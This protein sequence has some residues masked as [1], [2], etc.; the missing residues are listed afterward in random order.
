MAKAGR[1]LEELV[2]TLESLLAG[3]GV[4]LRSPEIIR[5]KVSKTP[6]EIDVTMRSRIG[7]TPVLVMME[8]R[9][10][11]RIQDVQWI[12]EIAGKKED[13]GA[14]KAVAVSRKGFSAAARNAAEFKGIELRTLG[15]VDAASLSSWLNTDTLTVK[16]RYSAPRNVKIFAS[17]SAAPELMSAAADILTRPNATSE[18][19][20]KVMSDGSMISI[21]E[22]LRNCPKPDSIT[23]LEPGETKINTVSLP[24]PDSASWLAVATSAGDLDLD[25]IQIEGEFWVEH[26]EVP[27]SRYEYR[28]ADELLADGALAEFEQNGSTVKVGLHSVPDGR[29]VM[30]IEHPEGAGTNWEAGIEYRLLDLEAEDPE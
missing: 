6:R 26:R 9:K 3:T 4:E 16:T 10:R 22:L 19:I 29:L 2:E 30:S 5:G 24:R 13:V 1:D 23:N 20:L 15:S 18:A 7:S 25:L 11:G 12:D 27:A 28:N 17:A 14:D 21:A 8:C